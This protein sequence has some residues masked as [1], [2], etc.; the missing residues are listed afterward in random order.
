MCRRTMRRIESDE[1]GRHRLPLCRRGDAGP[2]GVWRRCSGASSRPCCARCWRRTRST[3]ASSRAIDFDPTSDPIEKLPFTTRAELEHDQAEHP[4]YGTNLT[5]PLEQYCGFTRP[6]AAAAAQPM[7]WLDT[8]DELAVVEEALGHHLRGG[9]RDAARPD[10]LPV[11]LRPVRRLLG[12]VRER[13]GA[14]EP[15]AVRAA[16]CPRRRGCGS[17][18]TT[19]AR[20]SAARRPTRC[21]WRKSRRRKGSTWPAAP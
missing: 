18:S 16:G 11:L 17:C 21:G 15:L 3:A 7:R 9:G 5:Y 6:P 10:L 8:A 2:R 13:G 12:G 14:G 4:P 20:S 1:H 19:T